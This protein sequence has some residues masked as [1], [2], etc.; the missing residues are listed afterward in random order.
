EQ[1]RGVPLAGSSSE[2]REGFLV[3]LSAAA[4]QRDRNLQLMKENPWI[5]IPL[6]FQDRKRA[7]L[8]LEKGASGGRAFQ[9]LFARWD[10][11]NVSRLGYSQMTFDDFKLDG[12]QLAL[13]NMKLAIKGVYFKVGGVD[14]LFPSGL[15]VMNLTQSLSAEMTVGLLTEDADR[16]LRKL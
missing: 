8:A 3:K 6:V 16:T 15:A 1:R 14:Y 12:K 7:I 13:Q 2:V 10:D 4:E 11:R 5:D 9:Q